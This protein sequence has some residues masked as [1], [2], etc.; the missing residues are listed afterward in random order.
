MYVYLCPVLYLSQIF[1]MCCG[2]EA[3]V[4]I[5]CLSIRAINSDSLEVKWIDKAYIDR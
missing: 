4:P 5:P 2:I 3:S 1:F